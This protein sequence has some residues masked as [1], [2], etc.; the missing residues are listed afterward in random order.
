MVVVVVVAVAAVAG[1]KATAFLVLLFCCLRLFP[2]VPCLQGL[3][4]LSSSEKQR[5]LGFC[6]GSHP[7]LSRGQVLVLRC[8]T[9]HPLQCLSAVPAPVP[10]CRV[11]VVGRSLGVVNCTW[12]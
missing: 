10:A 3:D 12:G 4:L 1:G 8:R 11:A 6:R 7:V 2:T 9:H 5:E